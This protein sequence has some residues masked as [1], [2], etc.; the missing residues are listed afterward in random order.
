MLIRDDLLFQEVTMASKKKKPKYINKKMRIRTS[1][2]FWFT[3]CYF[4]D[5]NDEKA[6]PSFILIPGEENA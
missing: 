6:N 1:E 3:V 2:G 4:W 5:A